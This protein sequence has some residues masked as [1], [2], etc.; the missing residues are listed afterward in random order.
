MQWGDWD[1]DWVQEHIPKHSDQGSGQEQSK[2]D[3]LKTVILW[4][5]KNKFHNPFFILRIHVLMFLTP[6]RKKKMVGHYYVVLT[7]WYCVSRCEFLGF[8]YAS[9][10]SSVR[11]PLAISGLEFLSTHSIFQ[12]GHAFKNINH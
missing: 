3:R 1:H 7:W 8:V 2:V 11:N 12:R 5:F 10:Q 4:N 6:K 9:S